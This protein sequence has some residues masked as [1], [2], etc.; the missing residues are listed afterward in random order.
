VAADSIL[1]D[2]LNP[3]S[4]RPLLP[5]FGAP[6]GPTA[7]AQRFVYTP[8][9]WRWLGLFNLGD[10]LQQ[11]P[12]VFTVR[13]GWFGQP[14]TIAYAGQGAASVE[15][16][17]DGYPMDPIGRDS[18]G[19]DVGRY[20]L[21]MFRRIEIL[22][23]PTVLRVY[24]ESD[25]QS[26]R[27]PRTEVS[28]AT[29]DQ[30]TNSYRVRY[31]NRWRNG[32]GVG[33]GVTY[34]GTNGPTDAPAEI[35]ELGLWGKATWTP[36]DRIGVEYQVTSYGFE[37]EQLGGTPGGAQLPPVSIRRTDAFLR[38]TAAARGDGTGLRFDALF[39][40]T[41]VSDT[42]RTVDFGQAMT[43]ATVSYR[44]ERWSADVTGRVRDGSNPTDLQARGAWS[45]LRRLTVNGMVR[46]RAMLGGGGIFETGAGAELTLL[47][48]LRLHGDVRWRRIDDSTGIPLDTVQQVLDW[49]G[50]AGF[51]LGRYA[52]VDL[53]LQAHAPY[54]APVFGLYADAVP[55]STAIGATTVTAS[56]SL[57]PT[58]YLTLAGWYRNPLDER[59][60]AFEPPH[61]SLTRLTFRSAFLPHFRRGAFDVMAQ[62]EMEAWGTGAVGIGTLGQPIVLEGNTVFNGHIQFRLVG[63]I[64]FY[65]MRN[66]MISRYSLVPG[67]TQPRAAQRFGIIWEFT[68]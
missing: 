11:I 2:S 8:D 64:L 37:S 36:N 54:L 34:F 16:Y 6:P 57:R 23:T 55:V 41:S 25:T 27:R 68:N 42:S 56:Y 65:Q 62:F 51:A 12:G 28:F 26:L 49:S 30:Q 60:V 3:D 61:H 39:G 4:I 35:G 15:V 10:L 19:V 9:D 33:L 22:V 21:G 38:V 5:H 48:R 43:D 17:W 31:L 59:E 66:I 18:L 46:S 63:A 44:A 1:P 52:D 32:F 58:R 7:A 20:N 45:P 53:S 67:L 13:A 29:G 47:R 24:L 40:S 50:G 14:E